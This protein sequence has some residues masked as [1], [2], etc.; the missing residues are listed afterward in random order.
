MNDAC[1]RFGMC[2]CLF[3][4]LL[5]G[6]TQANSGPLAVTDGGASADA[7]GPVPVEKSVVSVLL[8]PNAP[9]LAPGVSARFSATVLWSEGTTTD[10]TSAV[11]WTTSDPSVVEVSSD[12]VA[13][14]LHSGTA[15]IEASRERVGAVSTT[16]A[17]TDATAKWLTVTPAT[18]TLESGQTA[19]L[20]AVAAMSD[21]S[22]RDVTALAAWVTSDSS[23]A[24]VSLGKVSALSPGTAQ[25]SVH[26]SGVS[27]RSDVTIRAAS[28]SAL[29]LSPSSATVRAGESVTFLATGHY[30]DGTA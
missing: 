2:L 9:T 25:L 19:P 23:L 27:G 28:L 18:L 26:Y 14:A 10:V 20:T 29:S 5:V 22:E 1:K 11:F 13:T 4:Y 30:A 8:L 15:R 12:G 3:L 16:V 24:K 7:S 6:C 17:A 21:G